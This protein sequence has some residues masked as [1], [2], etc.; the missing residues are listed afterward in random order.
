MPWIYKKCKKIGVGKGL[1]RVRL[2]N[3]FVQTM[4]E[5]IVGTKWSNPV[6]PERKRKV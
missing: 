5:K 2:K 6:K 1:G 3:W 4:V